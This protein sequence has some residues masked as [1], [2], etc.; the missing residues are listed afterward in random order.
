MKISILIEG[1]TERAFIPAV[2]EF[3]KPRAVNNMPR[4]DPVPYDGRIPKDEKL[5]N[6]VR[7]LLQGRNAADAVIALTDVYTGTTDFRD[8]ADAKAKMRAWVPGETRFYP[9]AALYDFE[10]WLLPYWTDIQ[11]FSGSNRNSPSIH[12]ENVNHN[13]P[14][15]YVLEEVFRTGSKKQKYI[16]TVHSVRI[17]KGKDLGVSAAVCPELRAFLNTILGLIGAQAI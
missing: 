2:R 5:R 4:L 15:A 13:K 12:P 16:K 7:N 10:A 8:A 9:H 11:R 1:A 17:L 6:Q 3:L 14:P